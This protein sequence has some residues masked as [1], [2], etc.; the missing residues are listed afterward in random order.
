MEI[1][2][3]SHISLLFDTDTTLWLCPSHS[4]WYFCGTHLTVF[5]FFGFVDAEAVKDS[6]ASV[7]SSSTNRRII[8][9]MGVSSIVSLEVPPSVCEC[10]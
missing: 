5:F 10:V 8:V 1:P 2:I 7:I 9:M 3:L 6:D 4:L